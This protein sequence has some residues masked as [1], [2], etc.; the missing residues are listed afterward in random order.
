MNDSSGSM[1]SN[2][3]YLAQIISIIRHA[4]KNAKCHIYLFGSRAAGCHSETSDFDVAVLAPTDVTHELGIAREMLEASNIPFAVDLVDLGTTS[5]SVACR[6]Q[7]EGI[8]L[9][10]N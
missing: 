2:D 3:R 9:W 4:L 1:D 6:I 10:S 7:E 8:L 5:G